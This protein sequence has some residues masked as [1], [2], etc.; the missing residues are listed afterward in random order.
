MYIYHPSTL[1]QSKNPPQNEPFRCWILFRFIAFS[2]AENHFTIW[3]S[4]SDIRRWW[5]ENILA[6]LVFTEFIKWPWPV[7]YSKSG[8]TRDEALLSKMTSICTDEY[9][10]RLNVKVFNIRDMLQRNAAEKLALKMIANNGNKMRYKSLPFASIFATLVRSRENS[11][12]SHANR[13]HSAV[14]RIRVHFRGLNNLA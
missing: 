6:L 5:C 1:K 14:E 11:H 12:R 7:L 10:R 3:I 2:K 4:W 13:L 8:L 9:G